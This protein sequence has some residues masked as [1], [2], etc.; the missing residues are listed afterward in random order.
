MKTR[1]AVIIAALGV[2]MSLCVGIFG[3]AA[4][5]YYISKS[6]PLQIS[7]LT[8]PPGVQSTQPRRPRQT[9][10]QQIQ[11]N[12]TQPDQTQPEQNQ[13]Q[14]TLPRLPDRFKGLGLGGALVMEVS[15]DSP[16]EKP[17]CKRAI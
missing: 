9:L 3:G 6:S 14:Q 10:P 13:P 11:P 4:A 8:L 16:L 15:T 7:N 12:Q 5:G 1:T 17:A 2:L